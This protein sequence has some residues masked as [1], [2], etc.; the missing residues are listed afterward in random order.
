MQQNEITVSRKL[1]NYAIG[2]VIFVLLLVLATKFPLSGSE[3][4][5][6]ATSIEDS[7]FP[8]GSPEQYALLSGQSGERSVGST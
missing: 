1:I 8:A 7:D 2:F 5:P 3:H 4:S 6:N